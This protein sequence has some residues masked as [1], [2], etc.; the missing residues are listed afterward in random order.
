MFSKHESFPSKSPGIDIILERK[1]LSGF[2]IPRCHIGFLEI[3]LPA[4][5]LTLLGLSADRGTGHCKNSERN[6]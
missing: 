2:D 3:V 1:E 5:S 6:L 4:S